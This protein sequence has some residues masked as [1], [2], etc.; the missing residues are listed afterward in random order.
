MPDAGEQYTDRAHKIIINRLNRIYR[1]AQD[2]IIK[3]LNAHSKRMYA[4]DEKKRGEL[5]AGKI[6]KGIVSNSGQA[7][8]NID[9][10]DERAVKIDTVKAGQNPWRHFAIV[11]VLHFTCST[12]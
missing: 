10:V 3:K 7:F 11:V 5:E 4:L 12:D 1:E 9:I 2:D 8:V 6:T